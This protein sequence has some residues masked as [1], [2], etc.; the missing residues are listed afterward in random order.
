MG[1]LK[2]PITDA[3]SWSLLY[4]KQKHNMYDILTHLC[5]VLSCLLLEYEL[6]KTFNLHQV[7]VIE[8]CHIQLSHSSYMKFVMI[9]KVRNS[10]R[11]SGMKFQVY[12]GSILVHRKNIT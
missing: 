12:T 1:S 5:N 8:F 10:K 3:I 7:R 6:A 4:T 2:P 9:L 11:I